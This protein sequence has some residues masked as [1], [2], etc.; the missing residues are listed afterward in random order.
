MLLLI[1]VALWA[2]WP[3]PMGLLIDVVGMSGPPVAPPLPKMPSIV[4]LP[5]TNMSGDPEQESFSEASLGPE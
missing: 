4:V 2:S 3:R 5:F 1:A